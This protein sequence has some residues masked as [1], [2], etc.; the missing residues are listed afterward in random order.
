[1]TLDIAAASG[2]ARAEATT[3]TLSL[4][5]LGHRLDA[6]SSR[7]RDATPQRALLHARLARPLAVLPLTLLAIPLGLAVERSRSLEVGALHGL[8]VIGTFT[9][10]RTV[11]SVLASG[12]WAGAAF[13][14]WI[15]LALLTGYGAWQLVRAP[16]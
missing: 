2:P 15:A 3:G 13:G 16:R 8:A 9:G 1:M 7:G 5:E 6:R 11:A 12:G 14:P 10:I 4:G